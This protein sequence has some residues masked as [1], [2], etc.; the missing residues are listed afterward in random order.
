M[1]NVG[2][3]NWAKKDAAA[4]TVQRIFNWPMLLALLLLLQLLWLQVQSHLFIAEPAASSAT[5]LIVFR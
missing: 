1:Q 5:P 2:G 4:R 3:G